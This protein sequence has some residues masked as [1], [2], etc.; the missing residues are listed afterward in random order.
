MTPSKTH[1]QL[2]QAAPP[3]PWTILLDGRL[4]A[5]KA[6][7]YFAHAFIQ[8]GYLIDERVTFNGKPTMGVTEDC[9]FL[10]HPQFLLALF[11]QGLPEV[12]FVEL[13]ECLH[14][15]L[16]HP[17][18]ARLLKAR[19]GAQFDPN[20][21]ALA[22]DIS[23]NWILRALAKNGEKDPKGVPWLKEPT[24]DYKGVFP[25]DF[26][27][28]DG[29][30]YEKYYELLKE[31]KKSGKQ[32][33]KPNPEM[34]DGS[35]SH[36]DKLDHSETLKKELEAKG[37]EPKTGSDIDSMMKEA[38]K[39]MQG[40]K[41]G[42]LPLG[43]LQQVQKQIEPSPIDWREHFCAAI[44]TNIEHRAGH[45]EY[46]FGRANR[47]QATLGYSVGVS[48]LPSP[49][50][51]VPQIALVDDTSGSV[52]GDS[53]LHKRM[54]AETK[55]ICE[56]MGCEVLLIHCDTKVHGVERVGA[57]S[58]IR[59]KGGGGTHL[60]P[61][62]QKALELGADVIG[63]ITDGEIG[64]RGLGSDPGVPVVVVLIKDY[65]H[66][67]EYAEREGWAT[68]VTVPKGALS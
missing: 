9:Q 55:G 66:D 27:L 24:G 5:R 41:P 46:L 43:L 26:E 39:K 59:A 1:S 15:L 62:I 32:M 23:I 36:G 54:I 12:A 37:F 49:R 31:Q 68:L 30:E 8:F 10:A 3:D 38:E 61:G 20:V 57:N 64:G 17:K 21:S 29:F 60:I 16:K 45:Q 53:K 51:F 40:A 18:R 56:S 4:R 7:V 34:G 44:S 52:V 42:A 35:P 65:K 33:P 14:T 50:E 25:S 28:P 63:V 11:V 48:V 2:T 13:H 19:E 58:Q 67:V 47:R 6:A 22:M